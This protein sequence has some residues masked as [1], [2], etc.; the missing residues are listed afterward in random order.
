MARCSSEHVTVVP[1]GWHLVMLTLLPL[2][3]TLLLVLPPTPTLY[4]HH[5]LCH[6]PGCVLHLPAGRCNCCLKAAA[7]CG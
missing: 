2:P 7:L 4:S 6:G 5:V 1:F 3:C